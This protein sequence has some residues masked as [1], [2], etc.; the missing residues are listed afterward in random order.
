MK[1]GLKKINKDIF[2]MEKY[3]SHFKN[4]NY[5]IKIWGMPSGSSKEI[6]KLTD[7]NS[8]IT[9]LYNA[10]EGVYFLHL[11]CLKT[12]SRFVWVDRFATK[13]I[14][15][16]TKNNKTYFTDFIY[17]YNEVNDF[18]REKNYNSISL[19]LL[20]GYIP[21]DG[22]IYSGVK[23]LCARTIY[24]CTHS[25]NVHH[26]YK[27][28]WSSGHYDY[29]ESINTIS[30]TFE[31][32]FLTLT[33]NYRK[34][35]IPLTGGR[36]SRYLLALALKHYDK[37]DIMTFTMGTVGTFDFEI[38][39]IISKKFN[40]NHLAIGFDRKTYFGKYIKPST[41]FK[42]GI[43]NHSIETPGNIFEKVLKDDMDTL[44]LSGYIGDIVFGWKHNKKM[45]YQQNYKLP[46]PNFFNIQDI[47]NL[48]ALDYE[49]FS[50]VLK[51]LN[52]SLLSEDGKY[53]AVNW[54]YNVRAPFFV[55]VCMFSDKVNY[56]IALPFVKKDLFDLIVNTNKKTLSNKDFYKDLLQNDNDIFELF[57]YPLKNNRGGSYGRGY[58][59]NTINK[60][61][62]RILSLKNGGHSMI[63]YIDTK[64]LYNNS[65]N[66]NMIKELGRMSV[67]SPLVEKYFKEKKH[68]LGS[69]LLSLRKS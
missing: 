56:P 61:A 24:N 38:P 37:K 39:K 68:E 7:L 17:K 69:L 64:N 26:S 11:T 53:E 30:K 54:F 5:E 25:V 18:K 12:N 4:Q 43:T 23:S 15:Y 14:F 3:S 8:L 29:S 2:L 27:I 10:L 66:E 51:K 46:S 34:F 42:N 31:N 28:K 67:L 48:I 50:S 40:I 60:A 52:S 36:D 57:K 16:W 58:F 20:Y 47:E 32:S 13:K 59:Y 49:N 9:N 21:N 35:L 45:I 44:I 63:N 62:L 22:T 55:N 1:N 41:Y 6:Y 33:K 65:Y 19:F